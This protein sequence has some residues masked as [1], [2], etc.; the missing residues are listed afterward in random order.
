MEM[1]LAIAPTYSIVRNRV[2][3]VI[4]LSAAVATYIFV[5]AYLRRT[6]FTRNFWTRLFVS[7]SLGIF[8]LA[9]VASQEF[10]AILGVVPAVYLAEVCLMVCPL[11]GL[12]S[13]VRYRPRSANTDNDKH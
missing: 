11:T 2:S 9:G 3:V 1:V 4:I 13:W 12:L 5:W 8:A 10:Q 6:S 7:G